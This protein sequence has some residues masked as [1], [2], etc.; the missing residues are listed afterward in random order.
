MIAKTIC[1]EIGQLY[2][3][4]INVMA[5]FLIAICLNKLTKMAEYNY[6]IKKEVVIPP[7]LDIFYS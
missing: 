7:P 2:T 6:R 1:F 3:I 4:N 5:G